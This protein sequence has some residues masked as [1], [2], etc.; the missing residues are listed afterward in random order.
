MAFSPDDAT[1]Y[2]K[3]VL[4]AF[5]NQRLPELQAG[6]RELKHNAD[7]AVPTSLDLVDLYDIPH[8]NGD[9][10][11][12][13][14]VRGVADVFTK[15]LTNQSFKKI[16]P[17]LVE[18]HQLLADRNPDFRSASFWQ[19][20]VADR[21]D[22]A[23]GRITDF[24]SVVAADVGV[25]GVVTTTRLLRLTQDTGL[26]GHAAEAD[27]IAAVEDAGVQVVAPVVPPDRKSVV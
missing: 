8:P 19:R 13:L 16:G 5:K 14:Q 4:T 15:C 25:L 17:T 20:R 11:V 10:A 22:R 26:A 12:D 24:A 21:A 23:R 6:L 7:R 18:L 2:R 27:I 1:E 9:A 3:R